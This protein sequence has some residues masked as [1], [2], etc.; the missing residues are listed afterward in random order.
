MHVFI[1]LPQSQ[2]NM[3]IITLGTFH[4]QLRRAIPRNLSLLLKHNIKLR[5]MFSR[6]RTK[7]IVFRDMFIRRTLHVEGIHFRV[8]VQAAVFGAG[9]GEFF[10]G[11]ELAFVESVAD[12]E[13]YGGPLV[14]ARI[15]FAFEIFIEEGALFFN[16][17]GGIIICPFLP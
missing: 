6:T 13:D 14:D 17:L 5:A 8:Q 2:K 10:L 1:Q 7:S 15:C 16:L 9:E 4:V 3:H 11:A 12:F